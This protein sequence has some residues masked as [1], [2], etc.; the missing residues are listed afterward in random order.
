MYKRLRKR[1]NNI[2][3]KCKEQGDSEDGKINLSLADE[4][5]YYDAWKNDAFGD[6]PIISLLCEI[7][8]EKKS[9]LPWKVI[10]CVSLIILVYVAFFF[11]YRKC[12]EKNWMEWPV[13]AISCWLTLISGIE[14]VR[15]FWKSDLRDIQKYVDKEFKNKIF[16]E[17]TNTLLHEKISKVLKDELRKRKKSR[18]IIFID[19]LDRCNPL[20]AVKPTLSSVYIEKKVMKS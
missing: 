6:D 4:Y 17:K 19:E 8:E 7:V 16:Q 14:S 10:F 5:L 12:P 3:K 9:K 1:C 11:D 20:F 18:F 2:C 13:K 15:G